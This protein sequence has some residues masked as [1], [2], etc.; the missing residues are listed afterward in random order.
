MADF[1][2]PTRLFPEEGEEEDG[3]EGSSIPALPGLSWF[4][5]NLGGLS[6]TLY[7]SSGE[8]GGEE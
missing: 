2:P 7:A 3:D 8:D 1:A 5:S 4:S 6:P